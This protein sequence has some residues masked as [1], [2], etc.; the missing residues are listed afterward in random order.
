MP[1]LCDG[2]RR[3]VSIALRSRERRSGLRRP[4]TE[5]AIARTREDRESQLFQEFSGLGL[6]P[7]QAAQRV[8]KR[9]RGSEAPASASVRMTEQRYVKRV[10][11]L[12]K[13]LATPVQSEPLSH[14]LTM[15][16]RALLDEDNTAMRGR[17]VAVRDAFVR[18]SQRARPTS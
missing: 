17:A 16:Y 13:D 7:R 4:T 8:Y 1:T 14:A 5:E 18:T 6:T 10:K 15:L 12:N 11:R 9:L 2:W 3:S